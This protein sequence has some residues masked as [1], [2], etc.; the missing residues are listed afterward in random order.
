MIKNSAN[1]LC[2]TCYSAKIFQLR[3]CKA[4]NMSPQTEADDM[5]DWIDVGFEVTAQALNEKG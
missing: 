5:G 1:E 3:A 2:G 4:C